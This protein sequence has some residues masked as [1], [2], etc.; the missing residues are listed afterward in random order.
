MQLEPNWA[1]HG[2]SVE[3]YGQIGSLPVRKFFPFGAVEDSEAGVIWAAQ[4][5]CGGSWQMEYYRKDESLAISGGLPDYEYGHFLKTLSPG[6]LFVT[7]EAYITVNNGDFDSTCQRLIDCH[8]VS[9]LF[10]GE[11]RRLPY[12]FNEYCTTWGNPSHD[13]IVNIVDTIKDKDFD[14]FVIDAGWYSAGDIGWEHNMGDWEIADNLFPEGLTVT[15]DAIRAAGMKPGIWFEPEVVG[16]LSKVL[17]EDAHILKRRGKLIMSGERY[18]FDMRD[19]W[20][21]SYLRERVIKFLA[22]YG[23]DYVKTDYNESIG[24]GCDGAESL[25]SALWDVIES[26]RDFYR[27]IHEAV[28][29]ICVELCS[30]GGH[31]L[32]PSFLNITDMASFSD[33]HE[34]PEIPV[35]AANLHRVMRPEKSQIWCVVREND[36][37]RRLCY[38]LVSAMLGVMC[39]SGDV[40]QK[41]SSS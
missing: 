7:P 25:G 1:R 15:L 2:I 17:S 26:S 9:D 33:A 41:I 8:E 39:I 13:N 32:E 40:L 18:F 27:E 38:S 11:G 6:G 34:T 14:Y 5:S 30:S 16:K 28:P 36:P 12:V 10:R 19:E 37:D 35:I 24:V 23:L 4:L 29:G 21:R 3:K 31:R 22:D 20:T